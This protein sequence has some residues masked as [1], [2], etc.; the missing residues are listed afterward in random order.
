MH[1]GKKAQKRE[2]SAMSVLLYT[3]SGFCCYRASHGYFYRFT[4]GASGCSL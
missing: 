3:E 4:G 1:I 2:K